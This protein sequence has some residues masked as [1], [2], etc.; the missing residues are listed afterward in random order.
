MIEPSWRSIDRVLR[1]IEADPLDGRHVR[2]TFND[3]VMRD[4]DCAFLLHGA[5]GGP[6]QD[7]PCFRQARI[8]EEARTAV[9]PNGLDPAADVLRCEPQT[10]SRSKPGSQQPAP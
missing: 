2:V 5:L 8:D 4:V 6:W 3:G 10:R 9:W 7:P 1:V